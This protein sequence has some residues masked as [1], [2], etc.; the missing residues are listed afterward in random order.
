VTQPWVSLALQAA[1]YPG[2]SW[3]VPSG[4]SQIQP[5][6]LHPVPWERRHPCRL[7]VHVDC[8]SLLPLWF[9]WTPHIAASKQAA[10][11]ETYHVGWVQRSETHHPPG[12]PTSCR[13]PVTPIRAHPRTSAVQ[14]IFPPSRRVPPLLAFS[15]FFAVIYPSLPSI[16]PCPPTPF[17]LHTSQVYAPFYLSHSPWRPQNFSQ[18][19]SPQ[20]L[21]TSPRPRKPLF[22]AHSRAE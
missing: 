16:G 21:T 6:L 15:A 12:P 8:G 13:H 17:I 2:L 22:H 7:P 14:K 4:Q 10:T 1:A 20:P 3:A 19:Q 18:P 5:R 9:P 11:S